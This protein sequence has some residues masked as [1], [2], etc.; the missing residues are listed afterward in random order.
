[1]PTNLIT[2]S[3]VG[4]L[5]SLW[6]CLLPGDVLLAARGFCNWGL[7]A[8]CKLFGFPC[9]ILRWIRLCM[10]VKFPHPNEYETG[11]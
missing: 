7:L 4:L 3:E 6:D 10:H 11:P 1:M 8:Q 2:P 9:L 5:Q